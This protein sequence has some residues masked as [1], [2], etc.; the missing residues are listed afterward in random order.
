MKT[1]KIII[2]VSIIFAGCRMS[3]TLLLNDRF[4]MLFPM[5]AFNFGIFSSTNYYSELTVIN[6][7]KTVIPET[8]VIQELKLEYSI[9]NLENNSVTVSFAVSTNYTAQPGQT[10]LYPSG[11]YP[12]VDDTNQTVF[13]F[14]NLII[15]PFQTVKGSYTATL[16]K[17]IL[18]RAL[19]YSDYYALIIRAGVSG[20][21]LQ[22]INLKIDVSATAKIIT[23]TEVGN[24]PLL[25]GIAQ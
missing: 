7:M 21:G 14:T 1:F 19:L 20:L 5:T 11:A 9:S 4:S 15:S 12:Y 10:I 17:P 13:V 3:S 23:E 25:S 24:I 18:I 16:S 2:L 8:V 6:D 22:R